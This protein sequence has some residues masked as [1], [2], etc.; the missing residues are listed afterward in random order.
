MS[1]S[2]LHLRGERTRVLTA[3]AIAD[4]VVPTTS[5]RPIQTYL[6]LSAQ[7]AR[8]EVQATDAQI[9]LRVL[10][11][12]LEILH[13]GTVVLPSRRLA[14]ILRESASESADF[15]VEVHEGGGTL[16]LRLSDGEYTLPV[17][18]NETLPPFS[19]FPSNLP[20]L[21]LPGARLEQMLRQ[22][23]FAMDEDRN[24]LVLSG[25][26][27]Q[28]S[29]GELCLAATDGK[30]LAEAVEK[31]PSYAVREGEVQ[32]AILPMATV[33]HLQRILSSYETERVELAWNAQTRLFFARLTLRDGISVELSS[34]LIEGSYPA[35][36]MAI[37]GPSGGAVTFATAALASAVRRASLMM[38]TAHRPI[39]INLE[40]GKAVIENLPGAADAG[41]A[42]IPLPC[43][44]DG[45]PLRIGVNARYLS[46]VL[47]VFGQERIA[48]EFGRGLIMREPNA[49]FLVMPITL[50]NNPA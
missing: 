14:V 34:R 46:E 23:A 13:P 4:A 3:V 42:R 8:T 1:L 32:Q 12:G 9:G 29:A 40:R 7:D 39:V 15:S 19:F 18:L 44:Y 11:P 27:L 2:G 49:T 38:T 26:L 50:P 31:H 20:A 35:Y 17:V 24:N 16:Q 43:E 6:Q 5:T 33:Q 41:I 36:R 25:L 45:K 28:V 48:I 30:V 47:R 37:S 21:A 10:V 22:T